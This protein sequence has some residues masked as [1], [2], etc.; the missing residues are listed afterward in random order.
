MKTNER[1]IV[2]IITLWMIVVLA[3]LSLSYLR[4]VNLEMEMVK[5]Q[6]DNTIADNV[7]TAGIREAM[8]LIREDKYKDMGDE[9]TARLVDFR[10]EDDYFEY[11]GGGEEW[12]DYPSLY[13]DV[14]FYEK[15]KDQNQVA[16]YYVDVQDESAKFPINNLNTTLD[17]IAHLIELSGVEEEQARSLAGTII[18]WRDADDTPTDTGQRGRGGDGSSE[19]TFYNPKRGPRDLGIPEFIIKNGPFNTLDELLLLPGMNA[20]ILYGTVDQSEE[21]RRNRFRRRLKKGEYLGL[22]DLFT[23]Y[24][25]QIN[26]NTVKAEVL[27]ALLFP[28]QGKD[29]ENMAQDWV[30][31]RN[32]RDREPYTSDDEALKTLDNSDMDDFHFTDVRGFTEEVFA[33]IRDFVSNRTSTF[34][35]ISVAEYMGLEKGFRAIVRRDYLNWD[36]LPV[37]GMDTFNVED[38]QQVYVRVRLIEPLYDAEQKIQQ[39]S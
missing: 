38:L 36:L 26:L 14:P 1:G 23:V 34:E 15:D 7:A 32:G 27:E 17:M 31:M 30:Q 10:K 9:M 4:L 2:L 3:T 6:R 12:A 21:D 39:I 33:T 25:Q 20:A 5:F 35:V 8:I 28:M 22:K 29:A 19:Y 11:D 13:V 24:T 16:Y 18:D 37:F